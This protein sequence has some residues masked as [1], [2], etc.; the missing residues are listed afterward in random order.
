MDPNE[1]GSPPDAMRDA[2]G[3]RSLRRMLPLASVVGAF[4]VVA[5]AVLRPGTAPPPPPSPGPP[6]PSPRPPA[7]V[8]PLPHRYVRAAVVVGPGRPGEFRR[9]L[10]G[11]ARGP[12]DAVFA[13]GDGEVRV[14]EPGGGLA[15]A[16]SVREKASCLGV[17]SEGRLAVG[18]PGRVDLYDQ[19]GAPFG[20][21][22]VGTRDNPAD[23]TAV[24]L[25]GGDVLIAD[26]TARVIRRYDL[27]GIERGLIGA[28]SKTGGFM[29]PN[30]SLDFDVDA[31]GVVHA[32]DSGRH[33]VTSWSLD[34][35]PVA[36]FG[37]FGMAQPEDFVGC[38]NP[39]NVAVAPD[40]S[41]VTAEKMIARVKVYGADRALLAVIGPE[42]FDPRCRHIYLT[43]ESTGRIVT[44]DPER[45]TI[46]VFERS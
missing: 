40:G 35:T 34:G 31:K 8:P 36:S 26:A 28:R 21:F 7:L 1:A 14:F 22:A 41:L 19:T 30:K 33:Q 43:V 6:G 16:W 25:V 37:K 23:V 42:H 11:L 27:G 20:G 39:V 32:A 5:A 44:G 4:G 10:S 17:A 2:R 12:R 9:S 13:L 46:E 18:S 3:E 38:C 24:R 45:R 15:R 29:L